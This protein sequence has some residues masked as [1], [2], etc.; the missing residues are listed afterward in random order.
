MSSSNWFW[1]FPSHATAAEER[2]GERVKETLANATVDCE[3]GG[4]FP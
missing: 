3:D 1:Q 2:E 4:I